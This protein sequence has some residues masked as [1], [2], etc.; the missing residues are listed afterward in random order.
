MA[1]RHRRREMSLAER[2]LWQRLLAHRLR[3]LGFRRQAPIGSY[4]VDFVC[5]SARLVIEIEPGPPCPAGQ[6]EARRSWLAAQGFR[7]LR[8]DEE[9]LR[10]RLDDVVSRITAACADPAPPPPPSPARGEGGAET[11]GNASG[12]GGGERGE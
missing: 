8:V 4:L 9:T 5:F 11:T 2:R 7:I 6:A 12:P 10:T 1:A 3:G